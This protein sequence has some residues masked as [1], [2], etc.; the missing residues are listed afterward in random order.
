MLSPHCFSY[1]LKGDTLGPAIDFNFNHGLLMLIL[2]GY[3]HGPP[4]SK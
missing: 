3:T 2:L 1:N 4:E